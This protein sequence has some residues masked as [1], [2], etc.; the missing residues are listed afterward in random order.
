M[1]IM[2]M[3][4]ISQLAGIACG[5]LVWV[6]WSIAEVISAKKKASAATAS[7]PAP[8]AEKKAL[9]DGKT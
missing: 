7:G 1:Q 3:L 9:K 6:V 2:T 5:A 4:T 8:A